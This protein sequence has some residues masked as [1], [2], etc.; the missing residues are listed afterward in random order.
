MSLDPPDGGQVMTARD[1]INENV[2]RNIPVVLNLRDHF[3]GLAI[4]SMYRCWSQKSPTETDP[5][6]AIDRDVDF[7]ARDCYR[8]ADAMLTA[9]TATRP[10]PSTD[11]HAETK[12]GQVA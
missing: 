10:A 6:F 3:A 11:A 4:E 9:R 5:D 1:P 7:I 8:L 12:K 2:T